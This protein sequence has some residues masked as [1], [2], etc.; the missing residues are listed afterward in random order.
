MN[1]LGK[2]SRR[3]L[4]WACGVLACLFPTTQAW[5]PCTSPN[6][7]TYSQTTAM[8]WSAWA[9]PSGSVTGIISTADATSGT[10]T[11]IY[12]TAAA[13]NYKIGRNSANSSCTNVT[14]SIANA[15]CNAPGCTLGTFKGS[16]N[17]GAETTFPI[18]STT[19]P[20]PGGRALKIGATATYDNTVT[21]GTKSPTFDIRVHYDALADATAGSPTATLIFDTALSTTTNVGSINY[22][23]VRAGINGAT[24]AVS[25]AGVM[26]VGGGGQTLYGTPAAASFNIIGSTTQ[27]VVVGVVSYSG[28]SFGTT[29]SLARC[30]YGAGAEVA[31]SALGT[32]AAPGA[33]TV[34][35]VGA[36]VTSDGTATAG[37]TATPS[38]TLSFVY[39]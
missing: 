21:V 27:T 39:T 26:T 4:L 35:L 9:K 28:A 8:N 13:G 31:C 37:Q 20:S 2:T 10:G 25:T 15:N 29:A 5:A 19:L 30:K 32:V 24:Y 16:W 11:K 38:F 22:G 3:T 34:L 14:I 33:G 12:G 17:G 1:R 23:T 7:F 18:T 6:T 36:T